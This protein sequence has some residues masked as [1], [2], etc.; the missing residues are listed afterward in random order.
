MNLAQIRQRIAY[1]PK[2]RPTRKDVL[3]TWLCGKYREYPIALTL[4]FSQA[5]IYK[6]ANGTV[7]Q[8][9]NKADVERM[10]ETF[11]RK[12]NEVV[13]GNSAKRHQRKLNYV[14][15]IEGERTHKHL[16][17]HMAIGNWPAHVR[18]NKVDALV[19]E[20]KRLV[21]G[22]AGQHKVDIAD[23]GWMEYMLKEVGRHDT[24]NVLWHLM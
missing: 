12:L 8:R 5:Y 23:S 17:V 21:I 18:F 7:V 15:V 3:R 13:L 10:T 1:D 11:M 16:H 6:N 9:L 4:T 19:T 20:A 24:D 22:I 2:A 14:P